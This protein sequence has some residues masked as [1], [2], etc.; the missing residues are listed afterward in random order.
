MWIEIFKSGV[1]TDS[2]GNERNF[3]VEDISSIAEKYNQ[4]VLSDNSCEAPVVIGHPKDNTPAYGWVERL[5]RRGEILLAKLKNLAP[6]LI[7]QVR[8]GGVQESIGFSV[9]GFDAETCWFARS[10]NTSSKRF[11]KYFF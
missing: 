4:S 11:E 7:E 3:S 6:E 5:A 8:Q 2:S 1:H 10:C 9:S